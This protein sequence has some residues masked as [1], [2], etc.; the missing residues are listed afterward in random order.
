[1]GAALLPGA[2]AVVVTSAGLA[3]R[4][5]R[6]GKPST[7]S[8]TMNQAANLTDM[9]PSPE[10]LMYAAGEIVYP[11]SD[12]EPLADN[13]KQYQ[14]IITIQVGLD[15]LFADDPQ[16]FV[17]GDL[18]WYPV[19]GHPEIRIGPDVMV[20]FGRPKG[21]RG[22]YQQWKEGSVAPQ[23]A[24]EILSPGNRAR[25]MRGKRKFYERYGVEEYYEYDPDRGS[26]KIWLRDGAALRA[27]AF[28]REWR[29]PLLGITFR[30]EADGELSVFRPDGRKFLPP[31]ELDAIAR[32]EQER[33]ERL[34]AKLRELGINPD[35]IK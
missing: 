35:E 7:G 27:V 21:H 2:S 31:V 18:L 1:M 14:Y 20:I 23:V 33:A 3:V 34:A 16:V 30:L 9:T 29:S 17:A 15:S 11:N 6:A 19:E 8:R 26:L 24:V 4:L 12:G 10:E 32:R 28:G 25:E 5:R 13:T 22:S